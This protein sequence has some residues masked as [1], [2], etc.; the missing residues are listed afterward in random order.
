MPRQAGQRFRRSSLN[1]IFSSPGAKGFYPWIDC[2]RGYF[3]IVATD[4][5]NPVRSAIKLIRPL[6]PLI[7]E[8]V[9]RP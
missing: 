9:P 5:H 4:Q 2:Q 1:P 3:G 6:L 8:R 7:E